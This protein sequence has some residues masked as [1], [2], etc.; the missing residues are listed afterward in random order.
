[1]FLQLF[2]LWLVGCNDYTMLGIE[3]RQQE[4]LVYPEHINFGHLVSG[5]EQKTETFQIINTGDE[6]L[7][8]FAPVLVS[9]NDRY[10]MLTDQEEYIIEA[11]ELLEFFVDYEPETY[12]SNGGY[13]EIVSDDEDE[14]I[15]TVTLEGYG[16]APIMFVSPEA[17][18][19]GDI[20]IGCDNEER[21]TIRNEGNLDLTV[22]SISQMVS[23]PADIVMEFGSLPEPPWVLVP[24]QEIDFL[25]S[26][27]PTD[28]GTD[29]SQ[30]TVLGN[31]PLTPEAV[32][33]QYGDGDVEQWYTHQWEQEE[34]SMLDV[35]WVIDNSGSMQS[36]QT[37]LATNISYFMNDFIL[38]GTDFHMAVIST[39]NYRFTQII[40]NAD[41]NAVTL[42]AQSVTIGTY[43]SGN[44]KGVQ[45]AYQSL[46]NSNYAGVGSQFFRQSAKLVLIFLS[47]EADH[48]YPDWSSYI[49]FFDQLKPPGYFIPYGIIGDPTNGCG[50]GWQGAQYGSGYF[51]LINYYGGKWYSIC[52]ADWGIQLQDLA[53]EVTAKRTFDLEE[54]DPIESTITVH[55]NGQQV[56]E[57][58]EYD[59][60]DNVVRF[61]HDHTPD[62]GQTIDIEYATWGC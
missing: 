39:D 37:N 21:I 46:S 42:L 20:S 49:S 56:T 11:G 60:Q 32:V 38:T 6:D 34:I 36:H 44:E 45:M 7:K 59:S 30:I 50:S 54:D 14:K 52:A 18:D 8:I 51:D 58:W 4:I 10:D 41:Q 40:S 29:E 35:L 55:V 17:F 24:G 25:V 5:Q 61:D 2:I 48:S 19:Y 47:D 28:I 27:I 33:N 23:Q 43:G 1:M 9:G 31:D 22:E 13:I 16:D 12:E 53:S 15:S 3:K 26:Y 57:G 62:P